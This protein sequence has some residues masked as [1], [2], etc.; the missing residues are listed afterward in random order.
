MRRPALYRERE[1]GGVAEAAFP[2]QLMGNAVSP[3]R[4]GFGNVTPNGLVRVWRRT[5][6]PACA[7]VARGRRGMIRRRRGT[8]DLREDGLQGIRPNLVARKR[9]M[10]PV[11][12]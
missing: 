2:G 3:P 8:E 6:A 12:R 4:I 10:Q 7:R 1:V 11:V 5:S 9:G